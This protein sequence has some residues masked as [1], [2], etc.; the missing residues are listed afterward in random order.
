MPRTA[1]E[2]IRSCKNRS[3]KPAE[4]EPKKASPTYASGPVLAQQAI[5]NQAVQR[6]L[7]AKLTVNPP[8]DEHEKEADQAA[9]TAMRMPEPGMVPSEP[10]KDDEEKRL[11]TK[12]LPGQNLN[13]I[14]RVETEK[15]EDE[16]IKP[17]Q[18]KLLTMQASVNPKKQPPEQV[19]GAT[20]DVESHIAASKGGGEPL[21]ESARAF[22]EPRFSQDFSRVRVHSDAQ[23][24]QA[25]R[26]MNAQAFTTGQDI[27]FGA[28]S[29]EVGTKQGDRLLAHELTHVVQQSEIPNLVTGTVR[30]AQRP[31][32]QLLQ[33]QGTAT[34]TGQ[35][36][37]EAVRPEVES[38]LKTFASAS[39]N[40]AKNTVA[41]QAVRAVIRAYGLS[42]TGIS[43]M[44]FKPDLTKFN[45]WTVW[46]EEGKQSQIE[47]GPGSFDK[48]FESLVH[49]VAHEIEH[50]RQN[51]IGGYRRE[52]PPGV[53]E[54][55][56]EEFLAYSGMVLNVGLVPGTRRVLDVPNP[57]ALPPLPPLQLAGRAEQ[58]LSYWQ[59]M[60]SEEHR[61]YLPEFEG[62]RDRLFW[63]LT[64]EAPQAL[65]HSPPV[66]SDPFSPE[67][68]NY[69]DATKSEWAEV[70]KVWRQF[71]VW[72]ARL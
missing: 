55:P 18:T 57:P 69:L 52:L 50:V 8:D 5:G 66:A 71:N 58:A 70:K 51:L 20:P 1:L 26:A 36:I 40:E 44:R 6:M 7:Q 31:K 11:Q 62:V 28:G 39:G 15:E 17:L 67:W 43:D 47:F 16:E 33:R 19:P 53:E 59:K 30:S 32:R 38:L 23:S 13:L 61:K 64:R 25:A 56:I 24:N 54:D 3:P 21:P 49:I 45:A 41:M 10:E 12:P 72:P 63:R 42:A 27:Y 34:P 4:H 48:G 35:A 60:S 22:V 14:Q 9:N 37:G 29:Y 2:R 68:Q 65:M 46:G